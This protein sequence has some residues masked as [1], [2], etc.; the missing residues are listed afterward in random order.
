MPTRFLRPLPRRVAPAHDETLQSY[1]TRLAR[2]NRLDVDALREHAAGLRGKSAPVPLDRLAALAGRPRLA[3]GHAVLELCTP[4]DLTGMHVRDRPRPGRNARVACQC[5]TAARGHS[6]MVRTWQLHEDCVCLRHRRWISADTVS[7]S[8]G[9]PDLTRQPEILAANRRHRGLIRSHGR[10][11][12]LTAFRHAGHIVGR[13]RVRREHDES[14]FRL[15]EIFHGTRDW[16]LP[17]TH[18]TVDAAA[19]P[20]TVAMTALLLNR[21][22]RARA[23]EPNPDIGYLTDTVRAEVAPNYRWH[24]KRLHGAYEPLVD[25]VLGEHWLAAEPTLGP[26]HDV[27]LTETVDSNALPGPLAPSPGFGPDPDPTIG[28]SGQAGRERALA[29]MLIG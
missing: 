8:A 27:I 29:E 17:E 23:V 2:V 9:Q 14:F 26:Y 11:A 15:L 4:E 28:S 6:G 1:L 5:C 12:V 25:T 18:P 7:P 16:R 20:Q 22:W 24:L 3:L 21:T 10:H 13:W 19:Y